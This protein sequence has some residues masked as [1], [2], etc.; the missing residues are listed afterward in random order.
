MEVRCDG[1][2]VKTTSTT[3]FYTIATEFSFIKFD[4]NS[5]KKVPVKI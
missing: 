1:L 3:R 2:F 5:G 4:I